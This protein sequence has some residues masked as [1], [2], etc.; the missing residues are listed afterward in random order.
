[1]KKKNGQGTYIWANG[2]KF[3]GGWKKDEREGKGTK[4]WANGR[5]ERQ[6]W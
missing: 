1:M 3:T 6:Y 2:D 4:T 5:I